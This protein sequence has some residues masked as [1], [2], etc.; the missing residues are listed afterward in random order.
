MELDEW[1]LS[2]CALCDLTARLR[3]ELRRERAVTRA[4]EDRLNDSFTHGN[5]A[6]P[7]LELWRDVC[8]ARESTALFSA[9]L[10]DVRRAHDDCHATC[11]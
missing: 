1:D 11:V 2:A 9:I 8:L 5:G 10:R 6:Q 7:N 4:A 3:A